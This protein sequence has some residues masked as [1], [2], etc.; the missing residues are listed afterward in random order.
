MNLKKT[1]KKNS[2][3]QKIIVVTVVALLVV[4]LLAYVAIPAFL[5]Y[6]KRSKTVEATT[7]LR[8]LYDSS[9]SNFDADHTNASNDTSEQQ[10]PSYTPQNY[11]NKTFNAE[12]I[13]YVEEYP[14]V[15]NDT[16][17]TN[18]TEECPRG[19]C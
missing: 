3:M 14:V 12:E 7:E 10:T 13:Y 1:G 6:I 5:K 11:T 17:R 8:K 9:V 18:N 2:D 4:G 16:N 15:F 19:V